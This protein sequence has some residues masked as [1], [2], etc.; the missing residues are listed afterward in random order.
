M[1]K[2]KELDEEQ[3]WVKAN[4][5]RIEELNRIKEEKEKAE[6]FSKLKEVGNSLLGLVGLSVDNF[7]FQQDPNTGGYSVNFQNNK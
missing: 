1:K 5:N 6:M 4:I 3:P 7:K 2:M